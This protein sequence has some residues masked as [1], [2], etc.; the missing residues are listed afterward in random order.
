VLY[1]LSAPVAER[2]DEALRAL[3]RHPERRLHRWYRYAL[4][5]ALQ[6]DNAG[7]GDLVWAWLDILA[8]RRVLFCWQPLARSLHHPVRSEPDALLS[9]AANTICG[10]AERAIARAELNY[11][12][13]HIDVAGELPA[14]PHYAAWCVYEAAARALESA[15]ILAGATYRA[16]RA[17]DDAAGYAALAVSDDRQPLTGQRSQAAEDAQLRRAVFWEWWLREA[18]PNAAVR[19]ES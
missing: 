13:A 12:L 6:E 7:R 9:L 10:T 16:T 2:A 17:I 3:F 11:A 15:C 19:A 1:V 18:L 5:T 8:T 14:S 4:Y